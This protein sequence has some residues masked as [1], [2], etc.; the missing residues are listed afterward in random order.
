MLPISTVSAN[1]SIQ[2]SAQRAVRALRPSLGFPLSASNWSIVSDP[3]LTGSVGVFK[4]VSLSVGGFTMKLANTL[5]CQLL[6][7]KGVGVGGGLSALPGLPA[8]ISGDPESVSGALQFILPNSPFGGLKGVMSKTAVSL[9]TSM[10]SKSGNSPIFLVPPNV[11]AAQS[12]GGWA[13]I[14]SGGLGVGGEMTVGAIVFFDVTYATLA[15]T[16]LVG[17]MLM[18][19]GGAAVANAKAFAFFWGPD[20]ITDVSAG[21]QDMVYRVTIQPTTYSGSR[22][23]T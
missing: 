8:D 16:L 10:D 6:T 19:L 17:P 7:L 1:S 4:F 23:R 21:V 14:V 13:Q 12:F 15:A 5:T 18:A 11:D 22:G 20:V 9:A 2:L 3:S